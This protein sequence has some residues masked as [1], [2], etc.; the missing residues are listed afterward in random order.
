MLGIHPAPACLGFAEK[1]TKGEGELLDLP[2]AAS[3]ILMGANQEGR[4]Q[5]NDL[6]V[7]LGPLKECMCMTL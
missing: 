5:H 3:D 6:T 7:C 2:P 4:G 1:E